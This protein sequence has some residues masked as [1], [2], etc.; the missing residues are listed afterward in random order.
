MK[1]TDR[2]DDVRP[3]PV[4]GAPARFFRDNN[5]DNNWCEHVSFTERIMKYKK[6]LDLALYNE[7]IEGASRE[8]L[9]DELLR[10][11]PTWVPLSST[12][13]PKWHRNQA[14]NQESP[15]SSSA[16]ADELKEKCKSQYRYHV[17]P[18]A[19]K[20]V[21]STRE[22]DVACLGFDAG[23]EACQEETQAATAEHQTSAETSSE[24]RENEKPVD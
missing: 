22:A 14:L 12:G 4:C 23:W 7:P 16:N 6:A 20:D 19:D 15:P 10:D 18:D 1:P 11:E 8:V 9:I 24:G 5:N 3:C 21:W 13:G 17:W 2:P